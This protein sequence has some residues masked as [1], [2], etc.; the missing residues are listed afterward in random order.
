MNTVKNELAEKPHADR[1]SFE[2]F[3]MSLATQ[4]LVL[5]GEMK[6]P[7]VDVALDREAARQ[8]IDIISMLEEKT[9]GNLSPQESKMIEEIV[10]NLRISFVKG[11]NKKS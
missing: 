10:H 3:V 6:S 11:A 2:A 4:S 5:M 1:I 9:K 7:G 8:M